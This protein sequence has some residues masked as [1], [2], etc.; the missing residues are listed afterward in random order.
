MANGWCLDILTDKSPH[1]PKLIEYDLSQ[2]LFSYHYSH[3][4]QCLAASIFRHHCPSKSAV[5]P[6]NSVDRAQR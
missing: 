5:K 1:L 6:T 2:V 4:D 3:R